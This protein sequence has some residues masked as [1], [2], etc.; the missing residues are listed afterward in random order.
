MISRG[1]KASRWHI[2]TA[3][4]AT[5]SIRFNSRAQPAPAPAVD[6][7]DDEGRPCLP[8]SPCPRFSR[9]HPPPPLRAANRHQQPSLGT[10]AAESRRRGGTPCFEYSRGNRGVRP[11][12]LLIVARRS[13]RPNSRFAGSC[14]TG[15]SSGTSLAEYSGEGASAVGYED[16]GPP[17]VNLSSSNIP[18]TELTL[19]KDGSAP[20]PLLTDVPVIAATLPLKLFSFLPL[21]RAHHLQIGVLP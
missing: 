15:A 17:F 2:P 6:D 13:L 7:D 16:G 4:T 10:L 18:R 5:L 20:S 9:L 11:V 12:L 21:H 3:R 14:H 1:P 19:L 8:P